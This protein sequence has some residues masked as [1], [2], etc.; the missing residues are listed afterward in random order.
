MKTLSSVIFGLSLS[1][2]ALGHS[3]SGNGGISY[4]CRDAKNQITYARLLDLW[5]PE[6]FTT[7]QDNT[8]SAEEQFNTVI[9]QIRNLDNLTAN[10][11]M[12]KAKQLDQ[13]TIFTTKALPLTN[14][15]IPD[16]EP[17]PGCKFEQVARYG[18]SN[19]VNGRALRINKEIYNSPK[20]SNTDRAALRLHEIIYAL[21]VA[22][23]YATDSRKTRR[24]VSRYFATDALNYETKKELIEAVQPTFK[25]EGYIERNKFYTTG[26]TLSLSVKASLHIWGCKGSASY[27]FVASDNSDVVKSETVSGRHSKFSIVDPKTVVPFK[28]AVYELKAGKTYTFM[29]DTSRNDDCLEVEIDELFNEN[30]KNNERIRYT[31]DFDV[32]DL[33]K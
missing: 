16:F 26:P 8:L 22:N 9:S 14:D 33:S 13:E 7:Y 21:D 15:A 30:F 20:F 4:V 31:N 24:I 27:K 6:T 11:I 23:R 3:G 19:E 10:F 28:P 12:K 5:E 1:L 2:T 32:I 18:F 29:T 25:Q 17:E